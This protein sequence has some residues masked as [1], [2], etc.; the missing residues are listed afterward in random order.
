MW[1]LLPASLEKIFGMKQIGEAKVY[2]RLRKAQVALLYADSQ[3]F[4]TLQLKAWQ[5][6]Y[7]SPRDLHF[8]RRFLFRNLLRMKSSDTVDYFI[9]FLK[10]LGKQIIPPQRMVSAAA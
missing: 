10:K 3:H 1:Q 4:E 2:H 9:G 5:D 7:Y 6:I 8:E